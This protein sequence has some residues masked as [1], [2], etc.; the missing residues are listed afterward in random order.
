MRTSKDLFLIHTFPKNLGHLDLKLVEG[1]LNGSWRTSTVWPVNGFL[2]NCI[3]VF[4]L[5][6]HATEDTKK[7]MHVFPGRAKASLVGSA[8]LESIAKTF[9]E[10]PKAPTPSR[11]VSA[12]FDISSWMVLHK[13]NQKHSLSYHQGLAYLNDAEASRPTHPP[14]NHWTNSCVFRILL[15]FWSDSQL[16]STETAGTMWKNCSFCAL[17]TLRK[18]CPPDFLHTFYSLVQLSTCWSRGQILQHGSRDITRRERPKKKWVS[19]ETTVSSKQSEPCERTAERKVSLLENNLALF[20]HS[21][22]FPN[23]LLLISLTLFTQTPTTLKL[24]KSWTN[25]WTRESGAGNSHWKKLAFLQ[26]IK[27]HICSAG[28]WKY[29]TWCQKGQ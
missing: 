3:F 18:L 1:K 5:G 14:L 13:S 7:S 9:R 20:V 6:R 11:K 17:K 21:K 15:D 28:E 19:M 10:H 23:F 2:Y 26:H 24:L 22:P 29:L 8:S 4:I 27:W 12:Q 25:S 16:P